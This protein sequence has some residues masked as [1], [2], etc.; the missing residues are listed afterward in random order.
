M[1]HASADTRKPLGVEKRDQ[2][3]TGIGPSEFVQEVE[4]CAKDKVCRCIGEAT[5]VFSI[6]WIYQ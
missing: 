2:E 5:H 3:R 1:T 6:D 4:S